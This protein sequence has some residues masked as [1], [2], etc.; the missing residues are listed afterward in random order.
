MS[1]LA[2]G[3]VL[4]GLD[5]NVL[6]MQLQRI[7]SIFLVAAIVLIISGIWTRHGLSG[8]M[9]EASRREQREEEPVTSM[10]V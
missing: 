6:G 9:E 4:V 2:A 5:A 8:L 3:T 10:S 1:T 7:D